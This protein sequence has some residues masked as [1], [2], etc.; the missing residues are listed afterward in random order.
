M[1]SNSGGGSFGTTVSWITWACTYRAQQRLLSDCNQEV[2]TEH[3]RGSFSLQLLKE[4][5]V[6]LDILATARIGR[7]GVMLSLSL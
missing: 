4:N 2:G 1:N 7:K 6:S 5:N 3:S